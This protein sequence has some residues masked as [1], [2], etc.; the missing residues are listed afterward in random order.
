MSQ[1][2][3]KKE[4]KKL[5]RSCVNVAVLEW[6]KTKHSHNNTYKRAGS[7]VNPNEERCYHNIYLGC[8]YGVHSQN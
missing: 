2:C 1:N 4:V 5:L 6:Y 3:N 8:N 7:I